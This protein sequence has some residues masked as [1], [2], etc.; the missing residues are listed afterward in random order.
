MNV[1][2]TILI[3]TVLG[4]T[5]YAYGALSVALNAGVINGPYANRRLCTREQE[6]R[7]SIRNIPMH[8]NAP[9]VYREATC[10]R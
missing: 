7:C 9:T 8:Y 3:S 6:R 1:I 10:R 2:N 5:S 4:D